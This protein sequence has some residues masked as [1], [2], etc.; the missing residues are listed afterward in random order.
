MTYFGSRIEHQRMCHCVN[1]CLSKRLVR[2]FQSTFKN[3]LKP[4]YSEQ[5]CQP[6]VVHYIKC[7]MPS[8]SSKWELGFVH[9][10]AKFTISRFVISR[11]ECTPSKCTIFYITFFKKK[12]FISLR[13]RTFVIGL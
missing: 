2:T 6:I 8:K 1:S 9:Y 10:I 5:V 7:N 4:R 3:T 13:V 12:H 11:F